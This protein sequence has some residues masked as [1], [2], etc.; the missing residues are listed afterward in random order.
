MGHGIVTKSRQGLRTGVID[1]EPRV[2]LGDP[3]RLVT[4]VRATKAF[5]EPGQEATNRSVC[6][7][8]IACL[9]ARKTCATAAATEAGLGAARKMSAPSARRARHAA[10]VGIGG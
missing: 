7:D 5:V 9:L 6:L 1:K 2:C 3:A 10:D 4:R 8:G